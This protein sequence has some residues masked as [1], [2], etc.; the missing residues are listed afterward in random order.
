[1]VENLSIAE[2]NGVNWDKLSKLVFRRG[3]SSKITGNLRVNQ[4][5]VEHLKAKTINNIQVNDLFTTT[6]DQTVNSVIHFQ[7]VDVGTNINSKNINGMDLQKEA[8]VVSPTNVTVVQGKFVTISCN[9][10][11]FSVS[12]PISIKNLKVYGELYINSSKPVFSSNP[13]EHS[14]QIY[15]EK[16]KITGNVVVNDISLDAFAKLTVNGRPFQTNML[17][18]YWLK[19]D[20]QIIPV[21][22]TFQNGASVPHLVTKSLNGINIDDYMIQNVNNAKLANFYFENVTV[23]GNVHLDQ[24]KQHKPDLKAID[25]KSVKYFGR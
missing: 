23:F 20:F 14:L 12:G 1:M 21:H 6:T 10:L 15:H 22:T 17:Q 5:S 16:V 7:S 2:I 24:K 3:I 18:S 13:T 19:N 9:F 11:Y 25:T 4:F 8:V